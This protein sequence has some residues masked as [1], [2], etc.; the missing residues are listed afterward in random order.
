MFVYMLLGGGEQE[1]GGK[2]KEKSEEGKEKNFLNSEKKYTDI[3]D[4]DTFNF[5][6]CK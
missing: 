5:D 2:K 1:K 6:I 3:N 4:V